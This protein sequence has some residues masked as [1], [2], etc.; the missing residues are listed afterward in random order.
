M[1][2]NRLPFPDPFSCRHEVE[3]VLSESVEPAGLYSLCR[4]VRFR[5]GAC[6][7]TIEDASYE[8]RPAGMYTGQHLKLG[9]YYVREIERIGTQHRQVVR[10]EI[11]GT[12]RV[13][14][15]PRS[16]F[17]RQARAA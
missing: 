11:V 12:G 17:E 9:D 14:Q 6:G 5:C 3:R 4:V 1:S 15:M 2:S 10:F 8:P 7:A 16:R 13:E